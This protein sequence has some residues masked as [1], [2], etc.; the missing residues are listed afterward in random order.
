MLSHPLVELQKRIE[1]CLYGINSLPR[2]K[3]RGKNFLQDLNVVIYRDR[4]FANMKSKRFPEEVIKV[5][6][7]KM[8]NRLILHVEC[9]WF[10][11]TGT[12]PK[13]MR[14]KCIEKLSCGFRQRPTEVI[15]R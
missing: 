8:G 10:A 12:Q 4:E 5:I 2:R 13:P 14:P 1:E 11:L 7:P 9:S 15:F 6:V 3:S